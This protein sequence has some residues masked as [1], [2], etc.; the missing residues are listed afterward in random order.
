MAHFFFFLYFFLKGLEILSV[1]IL[2][3]LAPWYKWNTLMSQRAKDTCSPIQTTHQ[4]RTSLQ[5]WKRRAYPLKPSLLGF[6]FPGQCL[7]GT[8]SLPEVRET[9][10]EK[11]RG[12]DCWS[13][14]HHHAGIS[15]HCHHQ[16][17]KCKY[18]P[19]FFG[20]GN[21]SFKSLS[22]SPLGLGWGAE[23]GSKSTFFTMS[24]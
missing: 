11:R 17:L 10:P 23:A 22:W 13:Q 4:E 8:I 16:I 24:C 9:I 6:F 18:Q 15:F 3:C 7:K 21:W 1:N 5:W 19:R 2:W 12:R 14:A 20:W